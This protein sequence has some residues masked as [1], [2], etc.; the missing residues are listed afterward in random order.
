M[1]STMTLVRQLCIKDSEIPCQEESTEI[2]M[3]I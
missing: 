2:S 1:Y 3:N